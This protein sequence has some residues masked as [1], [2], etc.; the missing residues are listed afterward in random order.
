MIMIV[1]AINDGI[2]ERYY[3][4]INHMI[5]ILHKIFICQHR[6]QREYR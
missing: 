1:R 3:E 4:L 6:C 2:L 5:L